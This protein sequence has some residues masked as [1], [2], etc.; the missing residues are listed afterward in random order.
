MAKIILLG[1]NIHTR[2]QSINEPGLVTFNYNL[3]SFFES[4]NKF[5]KVYSSIFLTKEQRGKK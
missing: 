1:V 4:Q 2:K 5:F 3:V